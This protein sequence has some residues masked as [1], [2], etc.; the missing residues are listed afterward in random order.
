MVSVL[1]ALE[2]RTIIHKTS[3][4]A[5]NPL[6]AEGYVFPDRLQKSDATPFCAV[7]EPFGSDSFAELLLPT[8]LLSALM[9]EPVAVAVQAEISQKLYETC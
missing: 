5:A 6:A 3:R 2:T 8:G 7:S 9:R 4:E 1:I